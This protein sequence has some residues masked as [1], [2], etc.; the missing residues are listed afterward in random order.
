VGLGS[1]KSQVNLPVTI[2]EVLDLG[3]IVLGAED[4]VAAPG[5]HFYRYLSNQFQSVFKKIQK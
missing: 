3:V 4:V 5:W 1:Y 2:G